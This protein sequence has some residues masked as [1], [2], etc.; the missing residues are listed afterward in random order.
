MAINK[1]RAAKFTKSTKWGLLKREVPHLRKH[2][3]ISLSVTE[4]LPAWKGGREGSRRNPDQTMAD[5]KSLI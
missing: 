5:M 1:G 2:H 4:S 3:N